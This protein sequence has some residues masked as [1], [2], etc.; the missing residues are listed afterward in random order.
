MQYSV[1][2]IKWQRVAVTAIVLFSF[3]FLVNIKTGSAPKWWGEKKKNC[4]I[5]QYICQTTLCCLHYS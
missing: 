1:L 2:L 5:L 3:S 4:F